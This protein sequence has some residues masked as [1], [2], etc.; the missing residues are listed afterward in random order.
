MAKIMIIEDDPSINQLIQI[1]LKRAGHEVIS[2]QQGLHIED[3][4]LTD[5]DL[6]LLDV[7]LPLI[8]G[9]ELIG[10]IREK[11][12]APVIMVTAL[13]GESDRIRGLDLGADDYV[14]KPFSIAELMSRV[15]AQLRRVEKTTG[16][17]NKTQVLTCGDLKIIVSEHRCY[18]GPQEIVLNPI[19]FKML[20]LFLENKGQVLSKSQ[21]YN[22]V[23]PDP[24]YGDDNTVMVHIR[25]LREKIEL[26]P[27]HPK[28]IQTIRGVGYRLDPTPQEDSL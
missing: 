11:T 17:S 7:M 18:R 25:R 23:W 9:F 14:L 4:T 21:I 27:N 6:F 20:H 24:F 16:K 5:I 13:T 26:S 22:S 15:S 19:E 2:K 12:W 28:Y 8:S 3:E 10:L 1:H